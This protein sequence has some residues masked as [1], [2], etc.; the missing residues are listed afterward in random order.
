MADKKIVLA[1]LDIDVKGLVN[2]A[3]EAAEEIKEL[4]KQL[5]K[6]ADVGEEFTEEFSEMQEVLS[7]L[8]D[9]LDTQTAAIRELTAQNEAL[10]RT[11]RSV[12][13]TAEWAAETQQGFTDSLDNASQ[14]VEE[15]EATSRDARE[16]MAGMNSTLRENEALMSSGNAA[17][18]GQAKTMDDYKKMV[19]DSFDSINVFNGGFSG[20]ISR[21]QEAGGVGPLLK[22]A[23]TGITTG[24]KGMGTAI[25]ANPVGAIIALIVLGVQ[26]LLNVFKSI[27]PIMDKVEQGMAALSAVMSVVKNAFVG[28][29]SGAES[30]GEAFSGLGEKM[31]D[32]ARDAAELKKAQQE[33]EESLKLQEVQTARNKSEIARLNAQAKDLSKSEKERQALLD[34]A[35]RLEE[36]DYNQRKKNGQEKYRQALEDL[37]IRGDL[38]D[39]EMEDFKKLS[40]AQI[41]TNS[42]MT[43]E[44]AAELQER[45]KKYRDFIEARSGDTE[46]LFK[47]L[48]DAQ[49]GII[50]SDNDYVEIIN[51][52]IAAKN[53]IIE[54]DAKKPNPV[55]QNLERQKA[56]AEA[57][58]RDTY[59]IEEQ[60]Y[61][62]KM[63]LYK[64]D[65]QE[66]LDAQNG[67]A[68]LRV[69]H[70]QQQKADQREL[71]GEKAQ[72]LSLELDLYVQAEEGKKR[73]MEEEIAYAKEVSERKIAIAKAEYEATNKTKNDK[74]RLDFERNEALK[75]SEEARKE[76]IIAN[77]EK[78]Y[79]ATLTSQN[80]ILKGNEF[81]TSELVLKE[82]KR[83]D[84]IA[85]LQKNALAKKMEA[86]NKSAQEIS[87]ALKLID[88]ENS[89]KQKALDDQQK[90][91]DTA[92]KLLDIENR[93]AGEQLTFEEDMALQLDKLKIQ[94][95]QELDEADRTGA[96]KQS[97]NNKYDNIEKNMEKARQDYK[98]G[99]YSKAFGNFA[100][101]LGEQN[102]ASKAFSVAQATIDTYQAANKALAAYPPPFSYIAAG[103]AVA[104]GLANVKKI[105]S[106]KTPK[107]EKGALFSI[108]GNRHSN[109]GTLFTGADGTRFEAE[110]GELIGVMNRNAARHFMAFNNAF[111]AG[112]ASA[113]NYFAGGGI[114]SREITQPAMNIDELASRIAEAN[115][116]MPAPVVAVQDI[117]DTG[118]KVA[119]VRESAQF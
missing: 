85:E 81:L 64:K 104:S 100:S 87:D 43:A 3:R 6:L 37:R 4:R 28:L 97:I 102:A 1:K 76:A 109:G 24:I 103:A 117:L 115:R 22:N 12:A 99:L 63:E 30:A 52:N 7:E 112:G 9:R 13:T 5:E 31:A 88:Y 79:Q 36:D 71:L 78:E 2:A 57:Y 48:E 83:L 94:R 108:G 16:A 62:K 38:T 54:E 69:K 40:D 89:E 58:G 15:L 56:A 44:E 75:E 107:A 25:M 47:N 70:S 113:P 34:Q 11:Q 53:K 95:Q 77:A 93:R 42:N 8:T 84:T 82:K 32:A 10:A 46:E 23:F 110:Q 111:P 61:L 101:I 119:S 118:R 114:V 60:L 67:L 68:A 91:A 33:L 73:T 35:M 96:D 72:T 74:L 106:T 26:A 29:F 92:Q 14:A 21:A 41:D 27:T 55:I 65:T 17:T 39:R 19:T 80:E 50:E 20:F 59:R 116:T 49:K 66:F 51:N 105:V 18:Q 90:E 86:E 45:V 98:L